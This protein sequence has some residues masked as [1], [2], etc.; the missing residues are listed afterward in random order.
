VPSVHGLAAFLKVFKNY[1]A[2]QTLDEAF[3]FTVT[4]YD[5]EL[6]GDAAWPPLVAW[7]VEVAFSLF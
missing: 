2:C 5:L 4:P 3:P 6:G 7:P 1:R